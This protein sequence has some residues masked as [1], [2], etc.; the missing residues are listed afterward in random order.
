MP[1][2]IPQIAMAVGT[3]LFGAGSTG[4]II[5]TAITSTALKLGLTAAA[6]SAIAPKPETPS[7]DDAGY[8]LRTRA[9]AREPRAVI[10]GETLV[11]GHLAF[12]RTGGTDREDLYRIYAIGDGGEYDSIQEIRFGEEVLTLDG[13]GNV[14][15]PA[16]YNGFAQIITTLGS[17]SQTA[18]SE[19]VTDISEWTSNH[20]G[21][22]VCH[23]YVKLTYD[24]DAYA[25][26][27]PTVFFKVRGRK[28][29]DPRLDST[30]GGSGTH[31]KDDATTWEWTQNPALWVLDYMRGVKVNGNLIAGL[32]LPDALI[33]WT[34]FADAADACD[35]S[36]SVVGGG[37]INRYTGG[38]GMVTSADNPVGVIQTL[39]NTLA[40]E[41]VPRSGY[42]A[43]YAGE[44][45]TATVTLSDD[46]LA[47]PVSLK[48]AKSVRETVNTMQA[49][50]RDPDDGYEMVDA[51]AY[52]DAAWITDD[53][54]TF[55]RSLALPWVADHRQAQRIAKIIAARSREP[56]ILRATFKQKALQVREGDAFTWASDRFPS[57]VTGK[58]ICI[59]RNANADGTVDITGRSEDDTKYNWTAAS[60]EQSKTAPGDIAEP[61]DTSVSAGVTNTNVV[62]SADGNLSYN[63]G[64]NDPI[65]ALQIVNGPADANAT[66]NSA[67]IDSAG[68]LKVG[69]QIEQSSGGT[70]RAI[71]YGL[72]IIEVGDGDSVTYATA[73]DVAPTIHF[74]IGAGLTYQSGG[75]FSSGSQF[76]SFQALSPT[77][78]GFTMRAKIEQIGSTTNTNDAVT[79]TG[80]TYS[81]EGDK[82]T[83]DDA[84]DNNYI[85]SGT[86]NVSFSSAGGNEAQV[87]IDFYTDDGAGAV[88]RKS[89]TYTVVGAGSG[90]FSTSFTETISVSSIGQG[91]QKEFAI[92]IAGTATV[93]GT[94]TGTTVTS[95]NVNYQAGT[96]SA[97]AAA[98]TGTRT[99]IA[100]VGATLETVE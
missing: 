80:G 82:S 64:A 57:G 79:T 72:G 27:V 99:V 60:E 19:A 22:G 91:S 39:V 33:D 9:N 86:I 17:E 13:S 26:G 38:G 45:R 46:D 67:T 65:D 41:I 44:A 63:G 84:V 29:Y 74:A 4:A 14:T 98:T 8:Q 100:L 56:R 37:T 31:R 95:G 54:E 32:G 66:D 40:G 87:D 70:K 58:Y 42:V 20:R 5:A 36:V 18:I 51:P 90:T 7:L 21:R 52:S 15:S 77:T 23:A 83:S 93:T 55:A 97:E 35:E 30:N 49:A 81:Y 73:Y 11:G 96:A 78:S 69:T 3:T 89:K 12:E 25:S 48:T 94:V 43:L 10:Y 68:D 61:V 50:Y 6:M 92:D 53:G 85:F 47:G 24:A 75:G 34:A 2:V 71:P 1:Q 62:L 16:R 28:V 76:S 59:N 88:L